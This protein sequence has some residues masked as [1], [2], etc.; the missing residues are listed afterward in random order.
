[1]KG[2]GI[3]K[4]RNKKDSSEITF[5]VPFSLEEIESDISSKTNINRNLSKNQVI[6]QAFKFH[7]QGK[8]SE[9][10]KY[11]QYCLKKGFYDHRVFSNLGTIL[12]DI[13]KLKEAE[14]YT[15]KAIEL[16]PDFVDAH[17]N[18]GTILKKL[19]NL[20]GAELSTRKAIELNPELAQVHSNLGTILKDIGNFKEAELSFRK[21]IEIKPDLAPAHQNLGSVLMYMKKF[22]A[23]E[24]SLRKAIEIKGEYAIACRNL[25]ICLYLRGEKLQALEYILKANST[26]PNEEIINRLL[27]KVFKGDQKDDN[28]NSKFKPKVQKNNFSTGILVNNPL[29]LKRKV[30]PDLIDSLY[31]IKSIDQELYIKPTYGN[32][33]GSDYFLFDRDEPM[34]KMIKKDLISIASESVSSD[35]FISESFFTIS[36]SGAG[37]V[38]HN[39]LNNIDLLFGPK[40]SD[41]KFSLVYYLSIGDQ[42]CEEPGILKLENPDQEILPTNGLIILFPSKRKHSVFYKGKKDRVIIGINFYGI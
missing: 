36:R 40:L 31:K 13:G 42:D 39:H 24:K 11:Y 12:Q 19:G 15:R 16:N 20:K 38:S 22:N 21:A 2:F 5:S 30:E 29:I 18:L 10:A 9:A 8:I 33:R 14:I 41:K 1:M 28:S 7:S 37:L 3:K 25:S 32:A 4:K 26:D 23:A 35:I 17:S 34:I 27:I 6:N